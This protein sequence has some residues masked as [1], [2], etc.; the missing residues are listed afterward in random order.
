VSAAT[1]EADSARVLTSPD[2]PVR[3]TEDIFRISTLGL[4]W[5]LGMV[6][7][8]PERDDDHVV[9]ADGKRAGVFVL[10]GG[11]GD[12]K[13][14][15]P[16]AELLSSKFGYKVVLGTMPGRFYFGAPSRDW[17]GDTVRSDGSVRT[18]L[19]KIGD[20]IGRDE[21]DVVL[22]DSMRERYG[23]RRVARAKPGTNFY[24][25]LAGWPV[26]LEEGML[27]ASK[28]HFPA[29]SY[30]VYA[31]GHS[32]GGPFICMLS[33]RIVNWIGMLST[34]QSPFGYICRA[35]DRWGGQIGKLAGH[36][37]LQSEGPP[38]R[39]AFNDLYIRTWRDIARYAGPDALGRQG[40]SALMSLP[41]L[42]EDV[43]ASWEDSLGRPQFKAEYVVSQGVV[44]SLREA[45]L[46]TAGRLSMDE[47][48]TV[49]LVE[50]YEGYTRELSHAGCKPVPPSLMS[51]A[52]HSRD[53]SPEVYEEVILPAFQA[54]NGSPK[55]TLTRFDKGGHYFWHPEPGLPM[56]IAPSVAA[57][58]HDAITQGF[59]SGD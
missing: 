51:I 32:T 7:Y 15:A 13:S 40:A 11:E 50:R 14:V 29:D 23:V 33:Q 12:F 59:F 9:G 27:E 58:W 4:E 37:K 21:Y 28:R 17:P 19:W 6:V 8:A 1:I 31:Q 41:A 46:V 22:D 26:A 54:M 38:R 16:L 52:G 34:E 42:M 24:D 10:H 53:H 48:Q 36:E 55:V 30:S 56:G 35:R 45:A 5:D 39:D 18:P 44:E 47:P 57:L 25:R 2:R 49:A 20:E 43:Y 3:R